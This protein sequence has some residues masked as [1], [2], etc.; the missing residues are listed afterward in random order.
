MKQK[1]I[2]LFILLLL[3]FSNGCIKKEMLLADFSYIPKNPTTNDMIQFFDESICRNGN[4]TSWL[5]DFD[6]EDKYTKATSTIQNPSFRYAHGYGKTFIVTLT[7]EDSNGRIASCSKKIYI[8]HQSHLPDEDDILLEIKKYERKEMN[9]DGSGPPQDNFICLWAEIEMTNNWDKDLL[10]PQS[11][12]A[13]TTGWEGNFYLYTK[14]QKYWGHSGIL[15]E[16]EPEK[17]SPG[18]NATWIVTFWIPSTA[19]E[20]M[21]KYT[22][23]YDVSL[24]SPPKEKDFFAF[25]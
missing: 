1:L 18:E 25:L 9:I 15:P 3:P 20:Y 14:D 2:F 16:N 6:F 24:E 8:G 22:Y 21:I 19:E 23:L 13:G 17:I 5:W 10:R 12:W 4:I 7:I 11:G